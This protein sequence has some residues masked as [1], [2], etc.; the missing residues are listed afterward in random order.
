MNNTF[1]TR[2][3]LEKSKRKIRAHIHYTGLLVEAMAQSVAAG[4]GTLIKT[5]EAYRF[6]TKTPNGPHTFDVEL[7]IAEAL[8]RRVMKDETQPENRPNH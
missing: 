8:K 3:E 1:Y 5:G 2:E 4:K 7:G 6:K